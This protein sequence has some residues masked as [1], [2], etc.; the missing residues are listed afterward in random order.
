[1]AILLLTVLLI[2]EIGFAIFE[3]TKSPTKKDWSLRRLICDG[4]ELGIYMIM[5]LLP[6]IDT[7]FRFKGLMLILMIRIV[8]AG[9]TA[10]IQR[11]SNT[12]KKRIMI[13]FSAVFSMILITFSLIPAFIFADY[14]GREV[15]GEYS[16]GEAQAILIDH[17]RTEKFESDGSYREVPVHFY[18]PADCT[19][20][21]NEQGAHTMPLVIF[22]HGAFGYYQSN[23]STYMELA[24]HGYVVISLDHPYHSFFTKDS[25]GKLIT[26]DP[27][28]LQTASEV[29]GDAN[30]YS[31]EE[32]FDITSEWIDLRI[33]DENFV[34]D[35]IEDTVKNGFSDSWCFTAEPAE[36]IE[37][38]TDLV[39]IDKIGLMGHS[40]G[41]ATA[42]TVG[43]RDDVKAVIDLDGT[44][45]GEQTGV[46]DGNPIVNE[47]PYTTPILCINN[48]EHQI[49]A[50][51]TERSSYSYANNVILNSAKEGYVTYFVGSGHMNYTDLPLFAPGLAEKLGTGDVDPAR[52]IDQVNA[53]VLSFFDTYLKGEGTFSVQESY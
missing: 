31:E 28:F 13:V 11:K 8:I 42:V 1:M 49:E 33:K 53:I 27:K 50:L 32:T 24:S 29:G 48:E 12:G 46:E 52:C 10:L 5:I 9:I 30:P 36:K 20:E 4:I 43:R 34:L 16:V 7:S 41:G 44:M 6:G 17:S 19:T 35:T 47:E 21:G 45:L 14:H 23:A 38:I 2:T 39:D 15:T 3:Y 18:Y 22:S 37:N 26:V 51:K 25:D 40:L